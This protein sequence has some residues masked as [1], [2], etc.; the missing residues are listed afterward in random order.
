MARTTMDL[1]DEWDDDD[2]INLR[3]V[4]NVIGR[5]K[6]AILGLAFIV[7]LLTALVVYAMTPIYSATSLVHIQSEQA[8]IVS[9]EEIYGIGDQNTL[10]LDVIIG[11][12]EAGFRVGPAS[13]EK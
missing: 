7:T 2:G 6:W 4:W 10:Q 8:N 13:D 9:I 1:P 11:L 5:F 3:Q 12:G